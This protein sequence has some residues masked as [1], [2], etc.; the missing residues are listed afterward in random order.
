MGLVRNMPEYPLK[1]TFTPGGKGVNV[2]VVNPKHPVSSPG[3]AMVDVPLL[4]RSGIKFLA[5]I[6]KER[7]AKKKDCP[8]VVTG[9]R[10]A[11]KST[12]ILEGALTVD[13]TFSLANIAFHLR[14]FSKIMSANPQGNAE[15]GTFPQVDVDEAGHAIF[16]QSW[17]DRLQKEIAKQMIINRISRQIIWFAAPSIEDLNSTIRR[18]P[19]IWIHVSEPEDYLQGYAEIHIGKR[20]AHSKWYREKLWQPHFALIYPELSGPYWEEY[21]SNKIAFVKEV[22]ED[23][24]SAPSKDNEIILI[25]KLIDEDHSQTEIAEWLGCTQQAISKKLKA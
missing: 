17:M 18:I 21:E 10:G 25:Q 15:L 13:P 20:T 1:M 5:E 16:A 7:I 9:E 23:L 3:G 11:G 6:I 12:I 24:A 2:H 4:D 19:Y 8:I 22:T 14:D